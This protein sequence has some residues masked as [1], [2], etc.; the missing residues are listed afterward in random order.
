MPKKL[1]EIHDAV[2]RNLKGKTNPRTK[3]PYTDDEMWAIARAQYEKT[4]KD[5]TFSLLKYQ[6]QNSGK[7]RLI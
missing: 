1:D 6:L 3:K 4:K 7:K 5:E 2:V